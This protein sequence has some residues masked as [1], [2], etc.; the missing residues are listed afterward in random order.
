MALIERRARK[1]LRILFAI[2][3]E[4]SDGPEPSFLWVLI[5]DE[6]YLGSRLH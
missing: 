4:G 6:H 5:P 2:M 1:K 3:S